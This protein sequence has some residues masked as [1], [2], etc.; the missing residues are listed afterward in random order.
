M[1]A[2]MRSVRRMDVQRVA[3]ELADV[4]PRELGPVEQIADWPGGYPNSLA[5]C[6]IDSIQSIG[7]RYGSVKRVV[8]RYRERY[9]S[10]DR[11][12][13]AELLRTFDEAGGPAGW[14]KEIGTEHRTSTAAGATLKAEAIK[15]AALLLQNAGAGD[16]ETLRDLPP[17]ELESLK[18]LW[19]ALPGQRSG[20]S[21]RYLLM[22]AGVPGA[23][24]DRMIHRFLVRHTSA[25]PGELSNAEAAHAVE[26]AAGQLRLDTRALDH[27]MWTA[28]RRL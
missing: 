24:P 18:R 17:E 3:R 22:L 1:S 25:Q 26:L 13:S 9:P 16:N 23:K 11:E 7:V 15:A 20:I 6:V 28:A 19:L 14:A 4:V 5:L 27:A 2:G 12:G 8:A 21:W 10:A